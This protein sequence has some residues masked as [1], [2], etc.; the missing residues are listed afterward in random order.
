MARWV[1]VRCRIPE[2]LVRVGKS[3]VWLSERTGVSTQRISDYANTRQIMSLSIAKTFAEVLGCTIDE[4][5]TWR[6]GIGGE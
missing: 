2:L 3:R 6:K 5:Y 1:P 4:L